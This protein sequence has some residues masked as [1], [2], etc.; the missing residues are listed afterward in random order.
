MYTGTNI[1][2]SK[3]SYTLGTSTMNTH[4]LEYKN[5]KEEK[6]SARYT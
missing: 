1:L 4:R 2:S 3:H 6:I 5:R